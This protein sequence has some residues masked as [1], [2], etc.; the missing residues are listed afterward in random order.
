MCWKQDDP[1][2][3]HILRRAKGTVSGKISLFVT[4]N[5]TVFKINYIP[6]PRNDFT[7]SLGTNGTSSVDRFTP[8]CSTRG[9]SASILTLVRIRVFDAKNHGHENV[10]FVAYQSS[11]AG[12][13]VGVRVTCCYEVEIRKVVCLITSLFFQLHPTPKRFHPLVGHQR[14]FFS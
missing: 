7:L 13:I 10:R 2:R 8:D 6:S 1:I 5:T 9:K 11:Q 14:D 3:A 12:H 4:P